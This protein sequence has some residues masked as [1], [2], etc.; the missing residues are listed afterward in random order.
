[1]SVPPRCAVWAEVAAGAA[2]AVGFWAGTGLGLGAVAGV[3]TSAGGGA[4]AGLGLGVAAGGAVV[5]VGDAPPQALIKSATAPPSARTP[6][7]LAG[8]AWNIRHPFPPPDRTQGAG[9]SSPAV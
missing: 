9:L 8:H 3:A 6:M 5:A 7:L 4:A 1:M 2:V